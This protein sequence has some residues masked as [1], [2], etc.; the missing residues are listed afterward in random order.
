MRRRPQ[1]ERGQLPSLHKQVLPE[2]MYRWTGG[3]LLLWLRHK[4]MRR[5]QWRV[6]AVLRRG[7]LRLVPGVPRDSDEPVREQQVE[8]RQQQ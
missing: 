6:C 3:D 7:W 2:P 8:R 5:A 4:C 1:S